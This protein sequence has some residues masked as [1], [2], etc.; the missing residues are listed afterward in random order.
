MA[1]ARAHHPAPFLELARRLTSYHAG[2]VDVVVQLV[3]TPINFAAIQIGSRIRL[4]GLHLPAL[5][6]LTPMLHTTKHLPARTS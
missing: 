3:S 6:D 4:V 1:R 2:P 5:P